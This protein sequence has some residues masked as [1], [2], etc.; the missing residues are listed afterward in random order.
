LVIEG[1]V[2]NTNQWL[3]A[4][5]LAALLVAAT[6]YC[7]SVWRTTQSTSLYGNIILG[8]AT[9]L[10]LVS[11]CGLIVLIFYSRRKGFDEPARS[12][13]TARE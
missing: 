1:T 6:W 10:M 11:G 5:V 8:A 2:R 3:L 4:V 7:G 12:N 9:I 13:R